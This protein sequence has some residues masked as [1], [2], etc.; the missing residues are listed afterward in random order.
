MILHILNIKKDPTA[1]IHKKYC[2]S[3]MRILSTASEALD[4]QIDNSRM[5]GIHERHEVST[6]VRS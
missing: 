1:R 2:Y 4:S 5:S 6:K 3:L